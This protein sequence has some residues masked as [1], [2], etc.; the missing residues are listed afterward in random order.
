MSADGVLVDTSAWIELLRDGRGPAATVARRLLR[1][2]GAGIAGP[3]ATELLRGAR[4]RREVQAVE[5]LLALVR[6]YPVT[7]ETWRAAGRLGGDLARRGVTVG[8]VDLVL[9]AAALA[10]G[11]PLLSRDRHFERVAAHG[12]LRLLPLDEDA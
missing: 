12:D 8:T 10:A 1:E 7:D 5:R 9:S 2:G 4:G 11:V 6:W 3:V